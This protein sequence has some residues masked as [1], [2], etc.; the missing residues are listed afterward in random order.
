MM[1]LSIGYPDEVSE[2]E[3]LNRKKNGNPLDK[4]NAVLTPEELILMQ[5]EIKD[6]YV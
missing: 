3:I 2:I 4:I 1:R 6:V 5:E